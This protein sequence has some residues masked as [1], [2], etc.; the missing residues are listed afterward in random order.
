MIESKSNNFVFAVENKVDGSEGEQQL[1][2]YEAIVKSEFPNHR[3]LF[4]YLTADGEPASSDLWSTLS[5]SDVIESLQEEKSRHL[6]NLTD[7]ATIVIDHYIGLIRRKIVQPD[8][9]LVEQCRKLYAL[10]KDALDLIMRYGERDTFVS[11]VDQFFKSHADLKPMVV[12]SGRAFFLPNS[13][14][15]IVPEID[16]ISWWGQSRPIG[17]WFNLRPDNQ[18]RTHYRGWAFFRWS[19]QT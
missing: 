18:I 1:S 14:C 5:Y 11:A 8:Q 4:A 13:L 17:F 12:R 15:E 2:K 7:E 19:I 3:K 10:H 9:D 6:A 16:G